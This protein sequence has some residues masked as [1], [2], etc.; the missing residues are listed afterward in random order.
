MNKLVLKD[1]KITALENFSYQGMK[2][3]KGKIPD[4]VLGNVR[5]LQPFPERDVLDITANAKP[6]FS[7]YLLFFYRQDDAVITAQIPASCQERIDFTAPCLLIRQISADLDKCD[8]FPVVMKGKIDFLLLRILPVVQVQVAGQFELV[9]C[10]C[11]K[12][13]IQVSLIPGKPESFGCYKSVIDTIDLLICLHLFLY[14]VGESW[15]G[16]KE[17]CFF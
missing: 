4:Q 3:K 6:F 7:F 2:I 5:A 8:Y 17:K 12:I 1:R 9:E 13:F 14:F 11:N 15:Y 16:K 10:N